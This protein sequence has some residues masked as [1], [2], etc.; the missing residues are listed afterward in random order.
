MYTKICFL[1]VEYKLYSQ[2]ICISVENRIVLF[3]N[4]YGLSSFPQNIDSIISHEATVL[5][6]TYLYLESISY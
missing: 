5:S 1:I 6:T 3:C 4:F 2:T